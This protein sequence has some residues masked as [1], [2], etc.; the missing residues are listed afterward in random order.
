MHSNVKEASPR[1]RWYRIK[2]E[3]VAV[4]LEVFSF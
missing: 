2:K 4:W 3:G 1:G